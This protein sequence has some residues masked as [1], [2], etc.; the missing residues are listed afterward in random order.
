MCLMCPEKQSGKK[1]GRDQL[2]GGAQGTAAKKE[3]QGNPNHYAFTYEKH[4][5]LNECPQVNGVRYSLLFVDIIQR[6]AARVKP[7]CTC[8]MQQILVLFLAFP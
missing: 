8:Q 7:K 1:S 4:S 3:K 5:N 2:L 6:R